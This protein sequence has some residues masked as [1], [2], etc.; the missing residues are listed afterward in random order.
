M[1]RSNSLVTLLN[2]FALALRM[3]PRSGRLLML[4]MAAVLT[5]LV[6]SLFDDSTGTL[7]QRL[8][9]LGWVINADDTTEQRLT[10]IAIDEKSLA[11]VGAWPWPR[12]QMARLVSALNS[13]GV[14]LQLHDIVYSEARSGDAEL[15]SA[16]QQAPGS[17]IAQV[18]ALQS[19]Q[20]VQTGLLSHPV[21]GVNCAATSHSAQSYVAANGQFAS[22]AKGHI[23]PLISA[24]G[25]VRNVPALICVEG[26]AY[27]AMAIAALLEGVNTDNWN[28]TLEPGETWL[29]PQQRLRLSAYPGF[30]IPLD[31]DGNLRISYRDT[32]DSFLAISAVDVMAGNVEREL[33]EN[34]WVLVGTTAFG[35]GDIVPTPF[36]GATP[37]VELQA[38]LLTSLLDDAV[39]YTPKA[40]AW[41]LA[42]LSLFAGMVLFLLAGARDRAAAI[43]L[44][45]AGLLL[46][47]LMLA[48]HIQLLG[49]SNLWLGWLFP[50]V[51]ALSAAS[52][53]LLLE[54]S[55]LRN[56]RSRVFNNLNSYLPSE[57]AREIA[58]SLP[59]SS[60]NASRCDVTLLSAD[61]RNFAAFSEAR[62]PEESAAVLHFFFTQATA[63]VERHGGRVHEF[64]GDGLLAVWDGQNQ[65]SA[66]KAFMAA[67]EMQQS[68]DQDVLPQTP[69]SGLEPLALGIGIEQGPVLIG[70]IGPAHRRTHTMLGDT[71]TICLR[72]QEMTAELAQPVLLGECVARHLND[73][74]LESQGSYLLSGLRI[75]HCLFAPPVSMRVDAPVSQSKLKVIRGGRQ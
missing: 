69:P 31:S 53:L 48:L 27:P 25:A 11:Q 74:E 40:A 67:R 5:W 14:Q 32:P 57:V 56:E 34:T 21:S 22:I 15:L 62:P 29:G 10:V 58:F 51:Y 33:L 24:D 19:D 30:E 50:S 44:P 20:T 63:I 41:I 68:I 17:V 49:S 55:R 23:S 38:R 64:K 26:Q 2:P 46:P 47:A 6:L 16:L 4:V 61:L 7:E 52:L 36:G 65:S 12:E 59:S 73:F 72:I 45:I 28:L 3:M 42:A 75:P 8:G 39:P 43:G 13:Y 37:G 71:V 54:Q 1:L 18:P 60:I 70:S 35:T 66:Q 9:E